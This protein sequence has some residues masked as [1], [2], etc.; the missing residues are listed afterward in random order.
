MQSGVLQLKLPTQKHTTEDEQGSES[1]KKD[2]IPGEDMA[3]VYLTI[4]N[5][6]QWKREKRWD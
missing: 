6:R 5:C 1:E 4:T 2:Y 3:I